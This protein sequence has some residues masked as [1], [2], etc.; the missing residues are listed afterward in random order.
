MTAWT[1]GAVA[2]GFAGGVATGVLGAWWLH[3][4]TRVS[5]RFLYAANQ[6][7]SNLVTFRIDQQ[8]GQLEATGQVTEVGTPVCVIFGEQ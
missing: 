2:G 3:L 7:S 5:G 6:D 8:T 4:R 1:V